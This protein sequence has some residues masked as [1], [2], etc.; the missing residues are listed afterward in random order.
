VVV[1]KG[2][3]LGGRKWFIRLARNRVAAL[4]NNVHLVDHE[5]L[6]QNPRFQPLPPVL[7]T[8]CFTPLTT[9]V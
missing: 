2:W 1:K 7:I 8:S 4:V 9:A 6:C 3:Y 5:W